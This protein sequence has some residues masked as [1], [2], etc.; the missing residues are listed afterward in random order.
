MSAYFQARVYVVGKTADVYHL[1][2][3]ILTAEMHLPAECLKCNFL[4]CGGAVV[5]A[6]FY[7]AKSN[8]ESKLVVVVSDK[9]SAD[10]GS[11]MPG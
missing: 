6:S 10:A 4:Y 1:Y 3:L 8:Y 2:G 5:A 11:Q 9:A 7:S